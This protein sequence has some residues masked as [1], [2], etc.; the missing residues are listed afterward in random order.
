MNA[1]VSKEKDV[2]IEDTNLDFS[3]GDTFCEEDGQYVG[4]YSPLENG[5]GSIPIEL[6]IFHK[7]YW[8][9]YKL[10]RKEKVDGDESKNEE[11][12]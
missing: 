3:E 8:F 2:S 11:G 12:S 4:A 5:T 1:D 9:I 6:S 7:G 10:E